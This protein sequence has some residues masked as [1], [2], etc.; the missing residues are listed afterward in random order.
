MIRHISDHD[1]I[2]K[3]VKKEEISGDSSVILVLLVY[4]SMKIQMQDEYIVH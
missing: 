3:V 2:L 4:I 1:V